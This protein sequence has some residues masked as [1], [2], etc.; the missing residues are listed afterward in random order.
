MPSTKPPTQ[1]SGSCVLLLLLLF[2]STLSVS[3]AL[4]GCTRQP[5]T[6][7]RMIIELP[8]SH[9]EAA[10]LEELHCDLPG[11]RVVSV[12][13]MVSGVVYNTAQHACI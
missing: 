12:E 5:H 4:I 11:E 9:S 7:Q 10:P 6:P 13:R 3:L 2:T 1:W 8:L